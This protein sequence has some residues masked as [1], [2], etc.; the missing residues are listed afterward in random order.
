VTDYDVIVAGGGPSG[1]TA[2]I[3]L[4]R[5]GVRVLLLDRARFPREKPCGGGVTGRARAAAPVDLEPVVEQRVNKVRFSYRLGAFFDYEYPETLV[6][7]TQRLRLDAYLVE[8]AVA[9][10]AEL[11]QGCQTRGV[12][13][14]RGGIT[15]ETRSGEVT[16]KVVIG[17]DGANGGVARSL[18]MHP[19]PDPPV[20]LEANFPYAGESHGQPEGKCAVPRNWEGVLALELGSMYGGYGWSF[21]KAD[22]FNVGCGGWRIEGNR[23]REHLAELAPHYG[24][25]AD[26][27]QNVRGH[28]LPTRE[29]NGPISKGNV[30]LVGDAAGLVDPMSGEGIHSAF[31]SGRLA[32]EATIEYLAGK[33]K[34]L[35]AYDAAIEREL[36]RDIRAA[37]LLRDG[38][39][40]MPGTCYAVMK[41]WSYL[42]KSLCELMLG[43][44]TYE[45]FLREGGPLRGLVA[46]VAA[47]GR[48]Q[49][50][51][52]E[53]RTAKGGP[54]AS[55]DGAVERMAKRATE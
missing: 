42:Q 16:A 35:A 1:S 6:W 51:R 54:P 3:T 27:M 36:M 19:A 23:L 29:G 53:G 22:H 17:A 38:Y 30:L 4:A 37:A 9:A 50:R 12:S 46:V 15:V 44:K 52:R 20:A 55:Q 7:M 24:L 25:D 45:G 39:H 48:A 14:Q 32:A 33:T 34:T 26:T 40:L 31:V 43:R 41:R 49:R 18:N 11:R 2:A 13:A 10:G 28:H 47:A 21:P 8:Q 5:A